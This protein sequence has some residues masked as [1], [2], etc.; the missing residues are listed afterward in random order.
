MARFFAFAA[1]AGC[2]WALGHP[3]DRVEAQAGA[4]QSATVRFSERQPHTP[5]ALS[6]DIDYVNPDDPSGKPPAVRTIVVELAGGA[7]FDTTVPG[8]CPAS[9]AQLMAQGPGACPADSQVGGG[10]IRIDTG[11]PGDARFVEEDLTLLNAANQ[12]IFLFR[13]RRTGARLSSRATIDGGTATT[14]APPLPGAPPDGGAIDVVVERLNAIPGNSPGRGYVVTPAGCPSSGAWTNSIRFTYA[15]GVSQTVHTSS[16]CL[17]GKKPI[18]QRRHCNETW[19][20]S[21]ASDR[22]FGGPREDRLRGFAGNDRLGGGWAG[23][24]LHGGR[25]DDRLHGGKGNDRV[26][27]GSG[28]DYLHGGPNR[29]LLRGGAGPDTIVARGGGADRLRCGGGQ[30]KVKAGPADTLS[31]SC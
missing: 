22:H 15:D 12:L 23:D 1:L 21:R 25:G 11:F 6:I 20:G 8:R 10:Y 24:C 31:R 3:A 28:G 9:D 2:S 18:H 4:R 26:F 27:G 30:D 7:R 14:S 16:P 29:D 19:K 5:S 13:D 17:P